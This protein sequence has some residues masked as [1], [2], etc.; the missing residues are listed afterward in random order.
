MLRRSFATLPLMALLL[1]AG[2]AHAAATVGQPAPEF[3]LKDTSGKTVKLSDFRGKHVV[4]EWTNPGYPF[5]RKHY[6]SGNLPA[7]QKEA[8]GKGSA[9]HGRQAP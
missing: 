7:Q 3:T 1:A 8:M 4:L 2:T 5:V 6:N 9:Q